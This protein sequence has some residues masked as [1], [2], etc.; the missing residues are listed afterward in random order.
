[1]KIRLILLGVAIL[2][3]CL[4]LVYVRAESRNVFAE[5][6]LL[7]RQKDDLNVEYGRLILERATWSL[8]HLVEQE[9]GNKL[10]M[11]RPS[12]ERIVTLL[13]EDQR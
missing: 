8:H 6:H 1:M 9:A 10:G 3:S 4:G 11:A 13:A 2:T 12:D 5:L 7:E